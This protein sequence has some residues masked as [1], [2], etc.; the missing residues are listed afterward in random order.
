MRT[1]VKATLISASII[2]L[3]SGCVMNKKEK[4]DKATELAVDYMKKNAKITFVTTGYYW[5]DREAGEL[6]FVDGYDK[7]K[8]D[9]KLSVPV[10][11]DANYDISG[12]EIKK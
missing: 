5:A 10:Q 6:L 4:E 8:P 11:V 2:I 1:I 3:L 12:W 7:E 9:Q